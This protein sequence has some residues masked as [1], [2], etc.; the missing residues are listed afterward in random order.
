M[1]LISLQTTISTH[2]TVLKTGTALPLAPD[3]CNAH[4]HE[5]MPAYIVAGKYLLMILM[6]EICLNTTPEVFNN[7][8]LTERII[9][10]FH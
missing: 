4:L 8:D 3:P 1:N 7:Y 6:E 2:L 9:N 5:T 10:A